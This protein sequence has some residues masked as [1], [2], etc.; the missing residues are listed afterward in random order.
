[1]T[2]TQGTM[3]AIAA[4]IVFWIVGAYNRLVRLRSDLVAR[5]TAVDERFRQR[6]TLL[7][8]QLELLSTALAAAGPRLESLRAA[9]RQAETAR[10]HARTRPGVASAVTS[11]RVAEDILTDARA[12]LPV[13]ALPGA[14]LPE[15][16]T[17]LATSDTALS[18]ARADFNAAV[19]AYNESVRQFPTVLI[20]RLFSF[21]SAAAF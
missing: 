14:D 3:T 20:A 18:F 7:E 13:Q 10:E 8:R 6:Q 19:A 21:R 2:T 15:L 16:N 11:L 4:V 5:F 17:Q 12:R 1:M 9:C